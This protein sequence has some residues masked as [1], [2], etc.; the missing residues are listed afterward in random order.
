MNIYGKKVIL[1]AMEERDCELACEM[2]NDPEIEKL[3]TGWAFPL[4]AFAQDQW[5]RNHTT[6]PNQQHYVIE[7]MEGETIG[8]VSL[9]DIDWKNRKA[10]VGVKIATSQNRGNGYGTDALMAILRYAFDELNLHRIDSSWLSY[11][12]RSE[13]MQRNCGFREEGIRREYLFKDGAYHDLVIAGIL[14]QEY[15]D[16]VQ[17]NDYWETER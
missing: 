13:A 15:R 5:F 3:V 1:R 4:S 8:T 9:L 2:F 14:E 11:N 17:M 7:T 16:L 10:G 12:K 6:D